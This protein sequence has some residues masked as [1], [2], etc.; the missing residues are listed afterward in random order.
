[1]FAA[2]CLLMLILSPIVWT[3]YFI[4][5][6]P[7]LLCFREAKKFLVGL[8]VLST[9]ALAFPSARGLGIHLVLTLVLYILTVWGI[10]RNSA[11][12]QSRSSA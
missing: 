2:G 12:N 10:I 1:M 9:V 4:W 5:W 6:L 11:C 3:H 7:A 8:A